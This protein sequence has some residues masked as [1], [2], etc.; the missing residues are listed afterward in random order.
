[1]SGRSVQQ[2]EELVEA[3]A[4]LADQGAKR[5]ALYRIAVGHREGL[6]TRSAVEYKVAARLTLL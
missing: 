2:A 3:E 1:M 4:G 6:A 5:S